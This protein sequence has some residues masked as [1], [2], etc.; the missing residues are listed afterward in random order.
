MHE[1]QHNWASAHAR[2]S[3]RAW[4]QRPDNTA[5]AGLLQFR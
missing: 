4:P 3:A 5:A 1:N 2:T